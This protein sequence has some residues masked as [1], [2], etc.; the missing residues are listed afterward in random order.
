VATAVLLVD[1]VEQLRVLVRRALMRRGGFDVVAEAGDGRAAIEA[2]AKLQP[3]VV[4][5]DLGLPD[6]AGH[7]VLSMLRL[8][9]PEMRVVVFTGADESD[10][11]TMRTE[12]EGF[13]LKG[14]TVQYLV[15]L[16]DDLSRRGPRSAVFRVEERA[17][18]I[19]TARRFVEHHGQAWGYDEVIDDAL[20]V[21][22]ELVTNAIMHAKSACDVCLRDADHILRIEVID[23]GRGSP[24]L[25]RPTAHSEH[26]RGLLLVSAMCA[27]WGVDTFQDG[28][29]MVWAELTRMTENDHRAAG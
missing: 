14:D 3:D 7:D 10:K 23:A 20:I 22:S 13:V 4:V 16:L 17:D 6:L 28:R 25:Q 24:E 26:G 12:V 18:E 29:K 21:V 27:A 1:D 15:D 9:A 2:A 8:A 5:L 19:A 11:V